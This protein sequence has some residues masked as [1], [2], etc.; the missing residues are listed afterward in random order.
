MKHKIFLIIFSTLG[1]IFL[2]LG[3]IHHKLTVDE[4]QKIF[5]EQEKRIT[6]YLKYNTKVFKNV[7]FTKRDMTPMGSYVIDGYM[8]NDQKMS[9]TAF[10]SAP[11]NFQFVGSM[12]YTDKFGNNLKKEEKSIDQIEQEIYDKE[13]SNH[14]QH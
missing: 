11:D 1:F 14:E 12:S 8:N 4:D 10:A 3:G 2:I 13:H 7:T 5:N 6:L 9:F